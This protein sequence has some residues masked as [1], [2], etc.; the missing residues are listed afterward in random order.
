[1]DRQMDTKT[2][3]DGLTNEQT[4]YTHKIDNLKTDKKDLQL[5]LRTGG[6][7][8]YGWQTKHKL[9]QNCV[10][11]YPCDVIKKRDYPFRGFLSS[12]L[13]HFYDVT[14]IIFD[15]IWALSIIYL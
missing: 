13:P 2:N 4:R 9:C 10:K 14:W 3:K 15:T 8:T 7:Q 6:G 1:M 12:H 11:N 5:N